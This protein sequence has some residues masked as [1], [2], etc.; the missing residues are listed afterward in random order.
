M[1]IKIEQF[2]SLATSPSWQAWLYHYNADLYRQFINKLQQSRG[3]KQNSEIM[4][5]ILNEIKKCGGDNDLGAFLSKHYPHVI[6]SNESTPDIVG[7][8]DDVFEYYNPNILSYPRRIIFTG[9]QRSLK[10]T[11]NEFVLDKIKYDSII[12]GDKAYIEYL[13]SDDAGIVDKIPN[14]NWQIPSYRLKMSKNNG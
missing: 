10:R 9:D 7:E 14:H 4:T 3:C 1:Q 2:C 11:I 8:S 6:I 5:E 12:I 13:T